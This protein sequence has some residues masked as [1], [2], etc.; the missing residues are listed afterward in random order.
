MKVNVIQVP[1]AQFPRFSWWSKWIDVALYDH[2]CRP[3]LLQM[4]VSRFNKKRFRNTCI[5]G[6]MLRYT[7]AAQIGD[8]TQMYRE[9]V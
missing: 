4:Q 1:S 3:Y 7:S 5:T 8:L 6:V 9:V 2:E